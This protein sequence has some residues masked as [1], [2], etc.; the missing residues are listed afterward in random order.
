MLLRCNAVWKIRMQPL[1]DIILTTTFN[2]FHLYRCF[3]LGSSYVAREITFRVE[4]RREKRNTLEILITCG[5]VPRLS[6]CQSIVAGMRGNS[7]PGRDCVCICCFYSRNAWSAWCMQTLCVIVYVWRA[8]RGRDKIF[9]KLE[10]RSTLFLKCH[11][12]P[13]SRTIGHF[14]V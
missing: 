3:L 12:V 11:N 2:N 7:Q 9:L 4:Y 8:S 14:R 1:S 13:V 6:D 10:E 5:S